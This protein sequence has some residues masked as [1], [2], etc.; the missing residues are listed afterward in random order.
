M[1]PMTYSIIDMPIFCAA[2]GSFHVKSSF[3][4]LVTVFVTVRLLPLFLTV[5]LIRSFTLM[6]STL[7]ARSYTSQRC[8]GADRTEHIRAS[9]ERLETCSNILHT[10]N[11]HRDH[12]KA[13]RAG[14]CLDLTHIP[15]RDRIA[16]IAQN[17]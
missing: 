12:R 4:S 3:T 8:L 14:R 9:V 7:R 6:V 10:P 16:G 13:G 2:C 17:R 11:V 15:Q 5:T 1:P